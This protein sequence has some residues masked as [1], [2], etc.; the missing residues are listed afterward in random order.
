MNDK[1]PV[2][3]SN[4]LPDAAGRMQDLLAGLNNVQNSIAEAGG[5]ASAFPFIGINGD[6]IWAYGQDRTEV[7]E[8][9][10]WGID[11][12]T[13][14]HG[15]I[16]WPDQKSKDRKPLGERMVPANSPLPLLSTLPDV[17]QPYQLQFAFELLCMSGEDTGTMALYK[18]GSYGAKVI[19]QSLVEEL[20]KQAKIDPTKLCPV[21]VLEIRSYF[22]NEWKKTIYNPV[23]QIQRWVSF[24]EYDGFEKVN[25]AQKIAAPE[26]EPEPEPEP[27]PAP[28]RR[29][30][31]AAAPAKAPEPAP[32]PAGRR[33]PSTRT[34]PSA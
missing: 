5:V 34:Q 10:E 2:N 29:R 15:Y 6:G 22:H 11:C 27:A 20:R 4:N 25:G 31:A 21:V 33:K 1:L 19:V 17:G 30:A 32:A 28:T 12:R 16:A 9:S 13:M 24:D 26:P 8:G 14:Q 3:P 23:L 18:N 7:E